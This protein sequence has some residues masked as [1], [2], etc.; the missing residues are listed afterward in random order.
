MSN[1][2]ISVFLNNLFTAI[3]TFLGFMN[4][5]S[6]DYKY[7]IYEIS[8]SEKRQK[9]FMLGWMWIMN[10]M[11]NNQS[12]ALFILGLLNYDTSKGFGNQQTIIRR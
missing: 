9:N 6:M 12:D 8:V 5:Y 10:Y 3:F 2:S 11:Y 1:F 7:F 4:K